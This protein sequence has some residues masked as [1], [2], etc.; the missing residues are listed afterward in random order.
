VLDHYEKLAVDPAAD[1]RLR[2]APL[3]TNER[4]DLRDFLLSL[5]DDSWTPD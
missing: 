4:A 2:R 1:V 3:T 5:G